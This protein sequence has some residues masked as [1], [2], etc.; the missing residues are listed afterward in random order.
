MNNLTELTIAEAL[1]GLKNKDFTSVELKQ[2]HIDDMESAQV[3]KSYITET[4]D[5]ALKQSAASNSCRSA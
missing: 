2:A 5:S 1:N 3:L 4:T